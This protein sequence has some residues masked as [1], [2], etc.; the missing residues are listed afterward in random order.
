MEAHLISDSNLKTDIS[1]VV[2]YLIKKKYYVKNFCIS[3]K[4]IKDII[5]AHSE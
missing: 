4:S 3:H 1:Q 5:F 2:F